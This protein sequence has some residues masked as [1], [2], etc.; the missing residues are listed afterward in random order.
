MSRS[1]DLEKTLKDYLD[2]STEPEYLDLH[3]IDRP[4]T[5]QLANNLCYLNHQAKLLSRVSLKYFFQLQEEIQ[6]L[7][8]ENVKLRKELVN[9]T[10]EVVE[11][12]PLTERKVQDLVLRITEQPKEIEQQAVRLVKD[13]SSKLD[14]VEAILRKVE[15]NTSL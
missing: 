8:A 3:T 5:K 10:K 11:N 12:R 2:K 1:L 7:K 14:R 6:Q 9:L 13:L 15:G 4:T